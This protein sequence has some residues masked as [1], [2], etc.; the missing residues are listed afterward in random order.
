MNSTYLIAEG[1]TTWILISIQ[2]SMYY[3]G[4]LVG[5]LFGGSCGD[6]HGRIK[7]I[8]FGTSFAMVGAV[9][10]VCAQGALWMIFGMAFVEPLG[11]MRE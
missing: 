5:S 7:T 10:Q 8:G 1:N 11:W 2:V 4:T 9:L 6:Q 3:L